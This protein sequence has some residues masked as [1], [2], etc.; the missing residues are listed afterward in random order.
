VAC[1]V[2]LVV[3]QKQTFAGMT[4]TAADDPWWSAVDK[5][6]K[7]MYV[8]FFTVHMISDLTCFTNVF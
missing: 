6:F 1:D 4:S 8:V 3:V 7:T 2:C 5:T